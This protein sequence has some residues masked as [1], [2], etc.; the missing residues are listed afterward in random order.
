MKK[1][2]FIVLLA[3]TMIFAF[4]CASNGIKGGGITMS[5]TTPTIVNYAGASV[6][7]DIPG[8]VLDASNGNYSTVAKSLGLKDR[9]VFVVSNSGPN[10][11]FLQQWT[12]LISIETEVAGQIERTVAQAITG[13]EWAAQVN[14]ETETQK[15][16]DMYAASLKNVTL[17]GLEKN[18]SYWIQTERPKTGVKKPK[19]ASDYITEYTYFVVY[20]MNKEN[21][22]DQLDVSMRDID[23]NTDQSKFLRE[24]VMSRL[25]EA[26]TGGETV[27]SAKAAS[28]KE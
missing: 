6:G 19:A 3:V 7:A 27:S 17:N 18:A 1:L 28:V 16:I 4:S 9:K 22:D 2:K 11:D 20:S 15:M 23:T 21:F 26:I 13:S 14:N 5:K 12:D 10:K 25:K 24:Q 8:W